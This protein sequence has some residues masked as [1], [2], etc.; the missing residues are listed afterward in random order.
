MSVLADIQSLNPGKLLTFLIVDATAIDGGG[1]AR[2]HYNM[3]TSGP[4]TWD[5]E[6][7]ALWPFACEGFART[8]DQQPTPK[9]SVGNVDGS[10]SL[11]CMSLDDLVGAKVTRIRTFAKYLDAVNFDSGNPDADP[12]Q[13]LPEEVWY[14]ER[15][16]SET[17]ESVEF[18]LSSPLDFGDVKL[19]RRQIIAN[20]CPWAYRGVGCNYTGG[21]VADIDDNPT[22]DPALDRCGKRKTSC[23]MR[24]WPDGI[25]NFGGFIAAGL[26]RT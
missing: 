12:A 3:G 14:I 1:I 24:D 11:L 8:S 7:Y 10:I 9:L 6:E 13:T 15:K 26:T 23:D 21:P 19:P 22:S 25:K 16:A 20:H 4:L 2:F 18:E 17:V 5:G